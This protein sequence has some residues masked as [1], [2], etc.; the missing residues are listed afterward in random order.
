MRKSIIAF[1]I[2]LFLV[3][4]GTGTA[5]ALWSSQGTTTAT[6]SAATMGISQTGFSA[7]AVDYNATTTS[8]VAPI[9]V[10]NTGTVASTYTLLLHASS[11]SG[12][13]TNVLLQPAP[14]VTTVAACTSAATFAG[15][16]NWTT[17][18]EFS[19]TLAAGASLV[20][21]FKSSM[22]TSQITATGGQS[23]VGTITLTSTSTTVGDTWSAAAPEATVT[24][25]AADIAAPSRPG[26]PTFSNTSGYS[27]TVSWGASSDNVGVASY[28]L[29]RDNQ[30]VKSGVTSPY[31]DAALTRNTPYSYTIR[32]VDAAG[33]TSWSSA[34]SVRTLNIDSTIWL[35]VKSASVQSKC[36]DV[37]NASTASGTPIH[38]FDC[39]FSAN[40]AWNF[41]QLG[42][43]SYRVYPAHAMGT[44]W[45][46]PQNGGG[47]AQVVTWDNAATSKWTARPVGTSGTQFQFVNVS[48][49][50]CL[51]GVAEQNGRLYSGACASPSVPSQVFTLTPAR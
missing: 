49:G 39:N 42:D 4:A 12:I 38:F 25:T 22:T 47:Y 19:G 50:T 26:T 15:S 46:L 33:N 11:S 16:Y 24:Q 2:V 14:A 3:L 34:A 5:A 7:L 44:S 40:Q 17:L 1:G 6:V 28:A 32:A 18:P 43:G 36:V 35:S 48:T 45:A 9:T 21:C 8:K 27:T 30:L 37:L 20:F 31:L 23:M 41:Q 10:T 29:Y 13:A 51:T